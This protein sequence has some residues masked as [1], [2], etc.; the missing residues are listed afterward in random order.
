M[1]WTLDTGIQ[2][3][4]VVAQIS[5]RLQGGGW[6]LYDNVAGAPVLSTVNNQGVTCYLQVSQSGSYTYIQLQGHRLWNAG[7]HVGTNSSS[8]SLGRMYF[9]GA[10]LGATVTCDLYMSVNNNRAIIFI[11][12]ASSNY[13]SWGYAGGLG[14]M[15]GT[16]DSGCFYIITSFDTA[17][18]NTVGQMLLAGGGGSFFWSGTRITAAGTHNMVTTNSAWS[19]SSNQAMCAQGVIGDGMKPF[20]FPVYVLDENTYA[21]SYTAGIG[22][23]AMRGDLDGLYLCPLGSAIPASSATGGGLL[24]HLDSIT[25]SGVTYLVIQP[26]GTPTN[27]VHPITGNYVQGLAIVES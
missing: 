16:S 18:S 4:N 26:G 17:N 15:A 21:T 11:N 23:V 24:S 10:A 12:I 8:A 27:N 9:G 22:P 13:R 25:I 3:Q 7:T 2:L 6:T 14:T 5:T 20:V 19:N 1:T